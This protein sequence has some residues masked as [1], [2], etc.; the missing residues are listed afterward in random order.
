M[1]WTTLKPAVPRSWLFLVAGLIWTGVSAI[2]IY[3][4]SGWMY[5][6]SPATQMFLVVA[7]LAVAGTGYL[8][9]FRKIVERNIM[10]IAQLPD[11]PCLFAFTAW[12][13]Y[14]MIGGMVTIG[15]ALRSSSL[16]RVY[17]I[18]PYTMMGGMLLLGSVRFY[19]EFVRTLSAGPPS[20]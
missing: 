18:V 8:L 6:E 20:N 7:A 3:R 2:L 1:D 17:L 13:G 19:R 12:K 14:M 15:I 5:L 4:A 16:P 9:G 11:R 10:R